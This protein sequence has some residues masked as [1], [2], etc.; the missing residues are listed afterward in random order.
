MKTSL[1]AQQSWT[2]SRVPIPFFGGAS[3]HGAPF[4]NPPAVQR[5]GGRARESSA[6][7]VVAGNFLPGDV[8]QGGLSDCYL[9]AVLLSL[10]QNEAGRAILRQNI[11]RIDDTRYRVR[12]YRIS[13]RGRR[14]RY[15]P[16]WF[17]VE[18]PGSGTG[19]LN[20]APWVRVMELAYAQLYGGFDVMA[21]R[22]HGG[23]R[24]GGPGRAFEHIT[25]RPAE[26]SGINEG[27]NTNRLWRRIRR[28]LRSGRHVVAGTPRN[29]ENN[30]DA[31]PGL[32]GGH[33][34]AVIGLVGRG[35]DR[36]IQLRNPWNSRL[37]DD[38][39]AEIEG[40]SN[41]PEFW[42][43]FDD[44]VRVFVQVAIDSVTERQP[45]RAEGVN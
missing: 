34:Y 17:N 7:T 19:A 42:I 29:L 44:F 24:I 35:D 18:Y 14:R 45:A 30:S 43:P 39:A 36:R 4:F 21:S 5:K 32:I 10:T 25:G 23:T 1:T 22:E 15:R 41:D 40:V 13:H 16:E 31:P 20:A 11:R 26:M 2:R 28:A 12:L 3:R 38:I 8:E 37:G 27:T 6:R 33:N 9:M